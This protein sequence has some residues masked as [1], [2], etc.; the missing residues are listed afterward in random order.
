MN[1]EFLKKLAVRHPAIARLIEAMILSA[2]VYL[3]S[4]IID[5]EIYSQ[6]ALINATMSPVFLALSKYR[7]DIIK[8]LNN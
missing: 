4:V 3:I 1:I 2:V 7:R 5:G 6:Q 8:E